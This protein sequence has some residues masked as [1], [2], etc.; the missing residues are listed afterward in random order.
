MMEPAG[1]AFVASPKTEGPLQYNYR[2]KHHSSSYRIS[3]NDETL[4]E[5]DFTYMILCSCCGYEQAKLWA[6]GNAPKGLQMQGSRERGQA[7]GEPVDAGPF[8]HIYTN[9]AN[10]GQYREYCVAA[11]R[12]Q[13]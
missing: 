8:L 10:L 9:I 7:P 1:L 5:N 13:M 12:G 2:C 6:S 4:N 11:W 3:A